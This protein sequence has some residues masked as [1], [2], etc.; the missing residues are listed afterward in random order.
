[1]RLATTSPTTSLRRPCTLGAAGVVVLVLVSAMIVS[2][3]LLLARSRARS[4]T[5]DR[6]NACN[7]PAQTAN[8]LQTLRL[9]HIHLKF[10]LEELVSKLALLMAQLVF[11]QISDLFCFHKI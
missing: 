4:L 9:A 3:L 2:P 8:L 6:L 1:M 5:S 11:R 7:V 10:Q